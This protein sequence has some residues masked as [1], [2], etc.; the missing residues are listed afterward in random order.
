MTA[1]EL[2]Q[3][4]SPTV[5]AMDPVNHRKQWL[6]MEASITGDVPSTRKEN[7]HYLDLTYCTQPGAKRVIEQS[8]N[9]YLGSNLNVDTIV[10]TP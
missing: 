8:Q 6:V 4:I 3:G 1:E 9:K 2:V 10:G 7:S 5:S